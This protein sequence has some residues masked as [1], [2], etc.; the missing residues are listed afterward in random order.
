VALTIQVEPDSL[1]ADA[2]GLADSQVP[3]VPPM[4]V[5]PAADPVSQGVAAVLE[6]HSGALT[7]VVEHSGALRAHGG[8][9]LSH[10]VA[11]LRGADQDNAAALAA[12]AGG[13]A[14][15]TAQPVAAVPVPSAPTDVMLPVIPALTPQSRF[16]VHRL[17]RWW[18]FGGS[19]AG[20]RGFGVERL[21]WW[22]VFERSW[23]S[24]HGF[25]VERL[26]VWRLCGWW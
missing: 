18:F 24:G 21:G 17:G 14:L 26:C 9:V 13:A 10:V 12:V 20:D 15:A 19:W 11:A 16:G 2:L 4:A 25:G 7:T 3:I 8:A 22:W 23:A 1:T 5:A 6:A